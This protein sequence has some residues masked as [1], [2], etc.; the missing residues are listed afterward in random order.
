MKKIA[1]AILGATGSVGQHFIS[2]LAHHP[3]FDVV[4][5]AASERSVGKRYGEVV[6]WNLS[7]SIPDKVAKLEVL[8]IDADFDCRTVFSALDASVAGLAESRLAERGY[9]VISNSKNHRMRKDVPLLIPDVNPDHLEL[10]KGR[11]SGGYIVTNPNCAAVGLSIALKPILDFYGLDSVNVVTM[12]AISGAGFAGVSGMQIVDNLLP[13]ISGEEDKIESE[14][15]KILGHFR[16]GGIQ[17]N[18]FN[19]SSQCNRVPVIDG[20]MM[21]VSVKLSSTANSED[22]ISNWNN[23]SSSST[24]GLPSAPEKII[25]YFERVDYPQPRLHRNCGNGMQV[26]IGRLR[27]C[28]L[29]DYKFVVLS[30]N[31]IRGAAGGAILT[32]EFLY[33]N[34]YLN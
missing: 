17:Y 22:I 14:P 31:T 1:V 8:P 32:A 23:Y 10:L 13:Y 18:N 24:R 20:H 15:R 19:I 3:W 30:H 2:L 21:C 26:S 7:D 4:A 27:R 5:V 25:Q 6:N 16:E 29:F 28:P 33:K 11:R 34:S 12:Q 9:A